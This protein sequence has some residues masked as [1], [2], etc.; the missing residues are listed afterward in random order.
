MMNKPLKERRL[1]YY[2]THI[3]IKNY[4][5]APIAY[6]LDEQRIV[7]ISPDFHEISIREVVDPELREVIA[8]YIENKLATEF[9][10]LDQNMVRALQ[11]KV[12]AE[13]GTK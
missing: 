1:K 7:L 5:K 10:C 13:Y 3:I 12:L 9:P 11:E 6:S 8:D 4:M 2:D